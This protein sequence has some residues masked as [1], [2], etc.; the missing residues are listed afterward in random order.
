MKHWFGAHLL[1]LMSLIIFGGAGVG[2]P[3]YAQTASLMPPMAEMQQRVIEMF[4][5][6]EAKT[7]TSTRYWT[8]QTKIDIGDISTVNDVKITV[9]PGYS[10]GSKVREVRIALRRPL[11]RDSSY[12]ILRGIT[13]LFGGDLP[14]RIH[15]SPLRAAYRAGG[16]AFVFGGLGFKVMDSSSAYRLSVLD[17]TDN[18]VQKSAARAQESKAT[19]CY[20]VESLP[21]WEIRY[22]ARSARIAPALRPVTGRSEPHGTFILLGQKVLPSFT[23]GSSFDGYFVT[24]FLD[25]MAIYQGQWRTKREPICCTTSIKETLPL[26]LFMKMEAAGK[27]GIIALSRE[28]AVGD[29]SSSAQFS[30]ASLTAAVQAAQAGRKKMAARQAAGACKASNGLSPF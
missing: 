18:Y 1:A 14:K 11:I 28:Q 7:D 21:G 12:R 27:M 2:F 29:A 9:K 30:L 23:V 24:L 16:D 3:A 13:G 26:S 10:A 20:Q 5:C 25:E 19:R 4:G 15:N 17:G 22:D 6:S 8:C